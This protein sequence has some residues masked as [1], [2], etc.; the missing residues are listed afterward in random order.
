MIN[1]KKANYLLSWRA[2][3]ALL[4]NVA[5]LPTLDRLVEKKLGLP[6][7]VKDLVLARTSIIFLTV[8]FA[9]LVVAPAI[10]FVILG[11]CYSRLM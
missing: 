3:A 5:I 1:S 10:W 2:A 7:Q 6:A 9:A 8:G 11:E 4:L